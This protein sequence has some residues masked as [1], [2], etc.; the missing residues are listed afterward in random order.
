MSDHSEVQ[1]VRPSRRMV[2][3]D[4]LRGFALL[5][6]ALGNYPEFSLWAFLSES[7]QTMM[8]SAKA[9]S[10]VHWLQCLLVDG[11]FYMVFSVLF[12]I[13]F[14]IIID[15]A[16]N[17]GAN[18]FQIF[19]R[20]MTL[21]LLMGAAHMM[22]LWSGDIL[23]LYAAIGML[24]PLFRR[25]KERQLLY[26]A[27]FFL[28][29]PVAVTLWRTMTGL[30]PAQWLYEQWWSVAGEQGINESNFASWLRDADSYGQVFSFLIQGAVE[31]MWE[32]VGGQRYF[33]VLGLFLIGYYIGRR[34]IVQHLEEHRTLLNKVFMAGVLPGLPLS[35]FYALSSVH[36]RPWG[37]VTHEMLY[38]MSVYPLGL[39]YMA[40]LCLL[41]LKCRTWPCWRFLAYPG[42]MALSCYILQS[43]FGIVLFY[44]IGFGWG[45]SIGFWQAELISLGVFALE[46]FLSFVWLRYFNFG[47]LEWIWRMLTYGKRFRLIKE[48]TED[49]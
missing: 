18:G 10:V 46:I 14:T 13:G 29:L 43:V 39:A 36:G 11:K 40:G 30:D 23:L 7:E 21:L 24:L 28:L 22:F 16:M 6:I 3:L 33:K 5:G 37:T 12:G 47:L 8:P 1:P 27:A 45:T 2:I 31:R 38:A 4:A 34:K 32:F 20:R 9:D 49:K 44:G 15:R 26:W 42:R 35:V 25:C 17:R 41:Y 19:Y 48:N